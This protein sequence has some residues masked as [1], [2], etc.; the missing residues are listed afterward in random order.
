MVD[1]DVIFTVFEHEN[2]GSNIEA[3]WSI[4][5][6]EDIIYGGGYGGAR[7]GIRKEDCQLRVAYSTAL[8]EL[9]A[10]GFVSSVLK[11]YGLSD[12]NLVWFKLNP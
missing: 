4:P 9:R 7:Y 11:K 10:N 3:L 1:D 6:P 12:R 2:P 8:A 5:T